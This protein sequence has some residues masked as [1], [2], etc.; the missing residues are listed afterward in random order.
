MKIVNIG[1][2]L[3]KF[4]AGECSAEEEKLLKGWLHQYN[5]EGSTDLSDE[6]LFAAQTNMLESIDAARFPKGKKMKL[7]PRILTLAATVSAITL[8]IWFYTVHQSTI[9]S[10]AQNDIAPG[11]NTATLTLSNGKTI[12]LSD[13]KTGVILGAGKLTYNDGTIVDPAQ[14]DMTKQ[15]VEQTLTAATPH[16]GQ[17]QFILPD[18]TQVW[19]NAASKISF[20]AQFSGT[21]RKILLSGEA[22]FE[23]AK[24]KAKPFI[25]ESKGQEVTV[26]GT[27]FNINA[28]TDENST[29]TTLLEGSVKVSSISGTASHHSSN[30]QI[31]IPNQQAIKTGNTIK[32]STVDP[33]ESI[34]WKNGLFMFDA[35]MLSSIMK[36]VSRWYN[37]QVVYQDPELGNQIFSGSVSRFDKISSLLR[38]LENT[39]PV[40]FKIE[41]ERVTVSR[42]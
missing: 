14:G 40:K 31:L 35:E 8:G 29:K 22:Y 30:E 39:A 27:H 17:Y 16:G 34:A 6:Y 25:V 19:L 12:N 9:S 1:Q 24:N 42:K 20:P 23:V 21:T 36:R 3:D 5:M 10:N 2:L 41:G 38:K 4:N 13:T 7:W 28:Y 15:A 33:E 11:R 18:G 32:V 37:I 26:L